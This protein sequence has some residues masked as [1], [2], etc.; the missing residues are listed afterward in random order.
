M[1][2]LL[3]I[4]FALSRV[5]LRF[6]NKEIS[7]KEMFFWLLIWSTV[8]TVVIFPEI[9]TDLAFFIGIGRGVDS[10]FFISILLLFYLIF[11]LYVKIDNVDKDITELSIKISKN[12]HDRKNVKE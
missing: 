12:L 6:N 2:V 9:T 1:F 10:A 3:F 5:L 4:I 11:R 7:F 8:L